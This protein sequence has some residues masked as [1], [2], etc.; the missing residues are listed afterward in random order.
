MSRFRSLLLT[1]GVF[2]L[3]GLG[4]RAAEAQV[5]VAPAYM[6][7]APVVTY[8]P[9]EVGLFGRR[10]AYRPIVSYAPVAPVALAA[11]APVAVAAPVPLATTSYYRALP[12]PAAPLTTFYAPTIVT[13]P[14]VTTFYAPAAP[15]TTFYAPPVVAPVAPLTPVFPIL[16]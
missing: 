7:A 8:V 10:I 16:P 2:G 15:V 9:T 1:C 11:P 12:A 5:V 13:P 4:G 6:P 3:L 14:P